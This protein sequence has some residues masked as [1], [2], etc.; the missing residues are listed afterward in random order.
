MKILGMVGGTSWA[1]SKEYY[2]LINRGINQIKGGLIYPELIL[3]SL[4]Y[5]EIAELNKKND[6]HG[7]YR[8][9]SE[10]AFS[11]ENIGVEGIILCANTLHMYADNLESKLTVPLI[12]IA[13]VVAERINEK[14]ID[15]VGLL[16]TK[17]TMQMDFYKK[18]LGQKG[19][20]CLVPSEQEQDFIHNSIMQ[21]LIEE[22]YL[23]ETRD[24]FLRIIF[25]LGDKGAGGVILGC[26]EIPL[27]IKQEFSDLML[28][29]SLKIHS[30][31][32]VNFILS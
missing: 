7:I 13:D 23:Q 19:I 14:S 5:G 1:S 32:A 9:V 27:L 20:R 16:G 11:L 28:F 29:D 31:A 8:I 12:N 25:E 3:Y 10:A 15:T 26:T 21:E 2:Y 18:R 24:R 17:N 22:K 4:N 30:E 6:L